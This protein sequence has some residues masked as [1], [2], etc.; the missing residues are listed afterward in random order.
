MTDNLPSLNIIGNVATIWFGT[1]DR[2]AVLSEAVYRELRDELLPAARRASTSV[3]ALRSSNSKHFVLGT[4][5]NYVRD[6]AGYERG[7]L[8]SQLVQEVCDDLSSLPQLTVAAINGACAGGGAEIA[9]AC[10]IRLMSEVARIG[11][12]EITLGAIPGG[13]GSTRLTG[14]IGLG[15]ALD[16]I[17]SGRLLPAKEAYD[18][19]LIQH[20]WPKEDFDTEVESYLSHLNEK[21]SATI[22]SAVRVCRSAAVNA[23]VAGTLRVERR[24]FG[25]LLSLPSFIEGCNAFLEQ[26]RPD[27][28]SFETAASVP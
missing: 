12:P 4:N 1:A 8:L 28:S 18:R 13:G 11:L 5:V 19:G 22:R 21:Y 2:A 17:T 15:T 14:M 20:V 10:D 24:E 27:F 3:L 23:S 25:E 6:Q 7:T 16:A 26:R 9:L